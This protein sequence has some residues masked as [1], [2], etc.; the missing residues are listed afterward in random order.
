MKLNW[1]A[2]NFRAVRNWI[3]HSAVFH[4]LPGRVVLRGEGMMRLVKEN[5]AKAGALNR[6]QYRVVIDLAIQSECEQH[7]SR[8]GIN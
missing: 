7:R 6:I 3:E 1:V 4:P 8:S 5:D 2:D